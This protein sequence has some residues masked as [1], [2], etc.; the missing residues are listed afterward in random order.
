MA[1]QTGSV[2][3]IPG[4]Q[5]F[6]LY[7][8][9]E[10]FLDEVVDLTIAI[11][12]IPAPTDHE[13]TRARF[14]EKQM[15][16]LGFSDILVD[17]MGNVTGRIRGRESGSP[18]VIAAHT[19]TVFDFTTNLTV[20]RSKNRIAGPGVGDNSLGV[21]AALYL[22]RVF[23]SA[24]VHP[25]VDLLVTGNVGEEGLGNLRGIRAV[26]D[27]TPDAGAVIAVEGHN[28]G[29]VTNVAVG[30]KRYRVTVS[31]PGGHSWGD[32]GRPSAIQ[33]AA[34]IINRLT[35]IRLPDTPKTTLNVGT[36]SG[37]TSVNT[38]APSC[39]F[40]LDLRSI[41][42]G[43]LNELA[44]QVESIL[45]QDRSQMNV[46][47]DV[48]GLRPAGR[49]SPDSPLIRIASSVLESLGIDPIADASS[50]DANIPISR[51]I[52]AV[53]IGL[54]SGGNVHRVDE[55]IDTPPIVDGLYQ[56]ATTAVA[57][58]ELLGGAPENRVVSTVGCDVSPPR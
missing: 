56:L 49:V 9:A 53:C 23:E 4:D 6:A 48:L 41:D 43:M 50:T 57:V 38:I 19:D 52:P 14:V 44:K 47:W 39:E 27:A 33:I 24:G 58:A 21:A 55:Y 31:G 1:Q 40:L 26:L 7:R 28:L 22:G 25:A 29:R 11:S 5:G 13:M 42:A 45:Q 32:S 35:G 17:T 20:D 36:I 10:K 18:V 54:T 34:D 16:R 15:V 51:G 2:P 46:S 12:E 37:G 3:V 30:S 8:A